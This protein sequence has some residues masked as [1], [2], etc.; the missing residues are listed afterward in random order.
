MPDSLRG[1][2]DLYP[3]H[4]PGQTVR[5]RWRVGGGLLYPRRV[6]G[7]SGCGERS[8]PRG[9]VSP[10]GRGSVS[11]RRCQPPGCA[12]LPDGPGERGEHRQGLR[13]GLLPPRGAGGSPSRW[14]PSAGRG[15]DRERPAAATGLRPW[16]KSLGTVLVLDQI[17]QPGG[18]RHTDR[19]SGAHVKDAPGQ[20]GARA[21]PPGMVRSQPTRPFSPPGRAPGGRARGWWASVPAGP[22]LPRPEGDGPQG[23][24]A[25]PGTDRGCRAPAG[26]G[27]EHTADGATPE[28][29][30]RDRGISPRTV[31]T[32]LSAR[33]LQG[34]AGP[35]GDGRGPALQT[36]TASLSQIPNGIGIGTWESLSGRS[37]KQPARHSRFPDS[38]G[39]G[40]RESQPGCSEKQANRLSQNHKALGAVT[41][42]SQPVCFAGAPSETAGGQPFPIPDV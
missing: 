34:R 5:R 30:A 26:P 33:R 40:N 15:A 18:P 6:P 1:S 21:P 28:Q 25:G 22:H 37:E 24:P 12:C 29:L 8:A 4:V 20:S 11:P 9:P 13:D 19:P 36:Q 38:L 7:Q 41:C 3:L 23:P 31:R 35:V 32:P 17:P 14:S 27:P 10:R 39:T 16:R 2:S 42:E